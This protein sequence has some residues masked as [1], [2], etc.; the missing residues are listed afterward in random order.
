[1]PGFTKNITPA[2]NVWPF[3]KSGLCYSQIKFVLT[4]IYR[5]ETKNCN[6]DKLNNNSEFVTYSCSGDRKFCVAC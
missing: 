1:M 2:K 5:E 6:F 4:Q 3:F